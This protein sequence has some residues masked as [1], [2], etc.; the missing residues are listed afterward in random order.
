[1]PQLA[2]AR[3]SGSDW[4]SLRPPSCLW[5]RRDYARRRVR[6]ASGE[7]DA[8][9]HG[10]GCRPKRL[11]DSLLGRVLT[12]DS[13]RQRRR[14]KHACGADRR[15]TAR[16]SAPGGCDPLSPKTS[17]APALAAEPK[18]SS[19]RSSQMLSGRRRRHRRVPT[20]RRRVLG[21]H[22]T[23]RHLRQ[24][25]EIPCQPDDPAPSGHHEGAGVSAG[26]GLGPPVHWSS[27]VA[28]C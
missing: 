28:S 7:K 3:R 26:S 21:H 9:P 17:R 16:Q 2:D 4:R 20:M 1:V 27:P 6:P 15:P 24:A 11:P 14:G 23:V 25:E 5:H 8:A 13:R 19:L 10:R 18:Q 22:P 12:V